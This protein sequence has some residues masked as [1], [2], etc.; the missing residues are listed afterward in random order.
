[1]AIAY[2]AS[3]GAIAPITITSSGASSISPGA[4]IPVG[5]TI[6]VGIVQ[7]SAVTIASVTDSGGNSYV[8]KVS[9]TTQ[10]A[11]GPVQIWVCASSTAQ[12]TTGSTITPKTSSGNSTSTVSVVG[13]SGVLR[14][15]ITAT[16]SSSTA[17]THPTISLTTQDANNFVVAVMSSGTAAVTTWAASVGNL[18]T[19]TSAL[20]RSQGVMDNT[21]ASATSVTCTATTGRSNPYDCSAVELRSTSAAAGAGWMPPFFIGSKS[22]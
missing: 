2:I 13:Y 8:L 11:N 20:G 19:S 21:A 22:G 17:T 6:V 4:T 5:S 10:D 12:L 15:G 1:V 18:R 3:S 9:N 7:N 16:N 14:I